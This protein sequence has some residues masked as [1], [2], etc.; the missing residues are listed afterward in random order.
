VTA[1]SQTVRT[2][3]V[4][5]L[6][7]LGVAVLIGALDQTILAAGLPTIVG[8]FHSP[9]RL[10]EVLSAYLF[11]ETIATPLFGRAGDRWGRRRMLSVAI[12]GFGV[13]SVLCAVSGSIGQLIVFRAIQGFAAGGL[14]ALPMGATADL[15]A[16]RDRARLQGWF[17]AIFALATLAG[18]LIGGPIVQHVGWRAIFLVNLPPAAFALVLCRATLPARRPAPSPA[19]SELPL[20]RSSRAPWKNPVMP[21]GLTLAFIL[22]ATQLGTLA[23]LPQFLQV[24]RGYSPTTAGLVLVPVLAAAVLSS[25]LAGRWLSRHGRYRRI[26]LFGLACLTAAL[27]MMSQ[28]GASTTMLELIPAMLLFGTAA[29][30]TMPSLSLATQVAADAADVGLAASAVSFARSLGAAVGSTVFGALLGLRLDATLPHARADGGAPVRAL[31][32]TPAHVATLPADLRAAIAGAFA[33]S[34]GDVCLT[35]AAIAAVG[36]LLSH[37]LPDLAL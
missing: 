4:A 36:L 1:T 29:G 15:L 18:P 9:Q 30:M 31:I 13:A 16:P 7:G 24:A 35:A 20:G 10:G 5:A 19:G 6:T 17:A 2:V 25:T 37:R 8:V 12:T 21:V 14:L 34:L 3:P 23:F 11:A 33:T 27:A 22:G 32:G 26:P 28:L